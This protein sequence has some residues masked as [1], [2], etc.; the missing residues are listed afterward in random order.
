MMPGRQE[1]D[2]FWVVHEVF[3]PHLAGHFIVS[4]IAVTSFNGL[5]RILWVVGAGGG[6]LTQ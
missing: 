6:Q 4:L 2:G 5:R 1:R 3:D